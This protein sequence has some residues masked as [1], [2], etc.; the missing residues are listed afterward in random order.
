[1]PSPTAQ[2]I[3]FN[4]LPLDVRNRL[5]KTFRSR[6]AVLEDPRATS[7]GGVVVALVMAA[8]FIGLSIHF[9][10]ADYGM[11]GGQHVALTAAV[12]PFF[13][14][15]IAFPLALLLS[16][17]G[18]F[19]TA[20]FQLGTYIL[21]TD[22]VD[23]RGP[24]LT[25]TPL[26]QLRQAIS[27]PTS[28]Q[29]FENTVNRVWTTNARAR[30]TVKFSFGGWWGGT[31]VSVRDLEQAKRIERQLASNAAACAKGDAQWLRVNDVFHAI[32][33]QAWSTRAQT[34]PADGPRVTWISRAIAV[35]PLIAL[36]VGLVTAPIIWHVRNT[37]SL[38]RAEAAARFR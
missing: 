12:I 25:V 13:V 36:A 15:G 26:V 21:A 10:R 38:A 35:A 1:M 34:A 14:L 4:N 2:R 27:Y 32:R 3:H 5:Q 16:G 20:P 30:P 24:V 23:A 29:M 8:L 19:S 11:A 33:G 17:L 9:L 37:A 7:L 18:A 22:L 31:V 6:S 28:A